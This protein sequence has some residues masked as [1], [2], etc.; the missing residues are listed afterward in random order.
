MVLAAN[1]FNGYSDAPDQVVRA[2]RYDGTGNE[3]D[4]VPVQFEGPHLRG[5]H[6]CIIDLAATAAATGISLAVWADL[7]PWSWQHGIPGALTIIAARPVVN[8]AFGMYRRA[9]SH[10]SVP[11]L[12]HVVYAVIGG[13]LAALAIAWLILAPLGVIATTDISRS[14]WVVEGLVS[15]ALLGGVR[16]TIRALADVRRRGSLDGSTGVP[17]ILYGAGRAGLTV[18]RTSRDPRAGVR[19]VGF[20]DDDDRLHGQVVADGLR[21]HGGLDELPALAE[22]SGARRLLITMPNASSPAIRRIVTAASMLGL[23]VRTVPLLHEVLNGNLDAYQIRRVKVEDLLRRPAV[24]DHVER[25]GELITGKVVMI[26]GAGGSI[27]S[28]LAR[29]VSALRPAKLVL[30]DRAEGPLYVVQRELQLMAKRGR[31]TEGVSAHIANV[32]TRQTMM[33][34]IREEMPDIIFHAAAYKHVPMMEEHPS[35][36]IHVNVRGTMTVLDAAEAAGVQHVVFVSTDKA[37]RPS[38]VMGAT[39]RVAE[40]LVNH[41]AR[42][43][44]H[45]YVSVRFGN[46]LGSSGSVV[47]IF[48]Q[49]LENG[50][51]L[52]ITH[53]EM[54]RYFMTI[55]EAV[56]LILDAA[57][58]GTSGD[59]LVLDM[60]EPVRIADLAQDLIRL[61]GRDP[62]S[63]PIEYTGL[64][65]GE[66]LHEQLFYADEQ[67]RST[68]NAKV[69]LAGAQPIPAEIRA[70]ADSLIDLADGDHDSELRAALFGVTDAL[71]Q[72][73]PD[74]MATP[75][76]QRKPA[77]KRSTRTEVPIAR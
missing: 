2:L 53:P 50:E 5:R 46:V 75:E 17:T 48:Q 1:R 58:I 64:R 22:A 35:D 24:H 10:A 72:S 65:P 20:I 66:K 29:Q 63:V 13:S 14:Y 45:C 38:S 61:A 37:V 44:G 62:D 32:A 8:I 23:E 16:F 31:G 67:V 6:L 43:T 55:P 40:A 68:E 4:P 39:K 15:M 26:T 73:A 33:R 51:P 28:E 70:W 27:G 41:A 77:S 69:M 9:W 52:T 47:P 49:Q 3:G 57:A 36:A 18:L 56:W 21:V 7:S 59:L 76:R 74:P 19:P 25:V 71:G 54:T 30:I 11:E 12:M 34:R 42:R 60:G